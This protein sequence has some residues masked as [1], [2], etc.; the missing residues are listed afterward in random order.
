MRIC[1]WGGQGGK[2]VKN[3]IQMMLSYKN[4]MQ[5]SLMDVL[6]VSS[7]QALNNK[8]S[9]NRFNV[10]DLIKICDYLGLEIV[11]RDKEKQHDVVIFDKDDLKK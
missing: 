5:I 9:N 4:K 10:E 7:K 1:L 3:K 2:M 6:K 8:F 11:V